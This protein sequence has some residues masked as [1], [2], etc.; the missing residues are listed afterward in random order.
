[1][2]AGPG[3]GTSNKG[4]QSPVL[5]NTALRVITALIVLPIAVLAGLAGGL[6]LTILIGLGVAL[7]TLEFYMLAQGREA[8]GSSLVGLPVALAVVLAFHLGQ[9]IIWQGA[10]VLCVLATF[11]LMT[12]RHPDD[13]RRSLWQVGSTLAG[14]FYIAFPGAFLIGLRA[15]D[16]GVMWLFV[17]LTA[18]WGADT[19]AYLGGRFFGRTKLAPTLSPKKT[20]EGAVV[21]VIGGIVPAALL[22]A[23]SGHLSGGTWVLIILLPFVAIAGDLFESAIKRFF[24][25]KDSHIAGLDLFP[26]HGGVLDRMD[27][28][29]WV[30]AFTYGYLALTGVAV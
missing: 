20:V 17:V 15:L 4:D 29:I 26:G 2:T 6:F 1:M 7:A 5:S 8:Q 19:F 10:L 25:V 3:E 18:T 13:V 16:E 27:A 14:V 24:S 22:L 11:V 23:Q 9:D 30:S 28:L 21:G 12:L